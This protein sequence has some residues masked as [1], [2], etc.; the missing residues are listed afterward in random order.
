MTVK[1]HMGRKRTDKHIPAECLSAYDLHDQFTSIREHFE[2]QHESIYKSKTDLK[3]GHDASP[4]L[5]CANANAKANAIA[6]DLYSETNSDTNSIR[7][8]AKASSFLSLTTSF[9]STTTTTDTNTNSTHEESKPGTS[10][11]E[12][13]KFKSLPQPALAGT[14]TVSPST[15]GSSANSNFVRRSHRRAGREQLRRQ[16]V[17]QLFWRLQQDFPWDKEI[18]V[19][20]LKNHLEADTNSL[21]LEE[22]FEILKT[23][24][25]VR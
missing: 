14:E 22:L 6:E 7:S 16:D 3:N 10:W 23:S 24:R 12:G 8:A 21:V 2:I 25:Q 9:S 17:V 1:F 20:R 18:Q 4:A 13:N 15:L 19:L 11:T 5:A